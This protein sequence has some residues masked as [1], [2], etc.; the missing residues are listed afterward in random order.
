MAKTPASRAE[1][2]PSKGTANRAQIDLIESMLSF[3]G[4]IANPV[5]DFVGDSFRTAFA[6]TLGFDAAS[7]IQYGKVLYSVPFSNS[8]RVQLDSAAGQK[9]C[10]ALGDGSLLA[11]GV[12]T[13]TMIPPGS[14]VAV[15]A[16]NNINWGTIIGTFPALGYDPNMQNPDW[17][18][19]GGGSGVN[20]EKCYTSVFTNMFREGGIIDFSSG[21]PLDATVLD[22]G[23]IADTGLGIHIDPFQA[24]FRVNEACGVFLN[25]IDSHMRLAGVN[26]DIQSAVH[27]LTAKDDS[28]ENRLFKGVATYPWEALGCYAAN[29]KP[30]DVKDDADVQFHKHC[31]KID[32]PDDES[33][34]QSIYRYQEHGGYLGQGFR[35]L[36]MAPTKT[37]G[38]QLYGDDPTD[39]GVFEEG[40]GLDGSFWLRSAK[41]IFIAKRCL[42]PVPKE[43]RLPEDQSEGDDKDKDNYKFSGTFGGAEEHKVGDVEIE[44]ADDEK[45][46]LQASGLFDLL[47]YH[48][49]WK[50]VHP[51]HYHKED[52]TTP[53]ESD[54]VSGGPERTQEKLEFGGLASK[55]YLDYPQPKN[56]RID[57]RYGDVEYF[58]RECGVALLPDGSL[59]LYDGYGSQI[60]MTGGNIRADAPG[61]IQ[62]M[63]GRNLVGLGGDDIVLRAKNSVDITA[64]EHDIR[65]KAEKNVQV[66]AGN[67]G[68]GGVLIE[69]KATSTTLDFDNKIGEDVVSSGIMLKA[70]KSTIMNWAGDI[71]LRTGKGG[72]PLNTGDIVLD[73]SKGNADV[74]VKAQKMEEYLASGHEMF[75]G[76]V[77]DNPT[78]RQ[79]FTFDLAGAMIPIQLRVDGQMVTTGAISTQGSVNSLGSFNSNSSPDVLP[80]GIGAQLLQTAISQVRNDQDAAIENGEGEHQNIFGTLYDDKQ[81]GNDKTIEQ[82]AFSYRDDTENAQYGTSEFKLAESRWQTMVRLDLA[83]GGIVWDE[84]VVDYQGNQQLPWPGKKKWNDEPTLLQ[85]EE[86]TMYDASKGRSKDRGGDDSPYLEPKLG[87]NSPVTPKSGYKVIG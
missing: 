8:Y 35:R 13:A 40:L 81:P 82:A 14:R 64:G 70:A 16:P 73:A 7:P 46:L 48:M 84:P 19:Q 26:L 30:F 59:I 50:G 9:W 57:D 80:L 86:L 65:I 17:I 53:E 51:F 27:E 25:Y 15:W 34:Q 20:R 29:T 60:V 58:E 5:L 18:T 71:Y 41:S 54:G 77:D 74:I 6:S 10:C 67:C 85:L 37:S 43:K 75:I 38:K 66:L 76:P 52:Y 79:S 68:E 23:K 31:G 36:L 12:R 87:T 44:G 56:L 33:D 47:A 39:Y 21:R 11:M 28:G 3:G 72:N 62:L 83:S 32:L 78:V 4:M 42:I 22:W 45:H 1:G 69:S 61:D 63:P 55:M 49:N 24:W 2:G